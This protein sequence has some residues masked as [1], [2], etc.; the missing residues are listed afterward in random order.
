VARGDRKLQ[1]FFRE[2]FFGS[3]AA[4]APMALFIQCSGINLKVLRIIGKVSDLGLCSG[5]EGHAAR[6]FA[7][8]TNASFL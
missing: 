6:P 8:G 5:Q 2:W 7:G 3:L 1:I 4:M